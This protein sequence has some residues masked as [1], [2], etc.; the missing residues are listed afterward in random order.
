[1]GACCRREK[2][3]WGPTARVAIPLKTQDA[4]EKTG[5]E[6]AVVFFVR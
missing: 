5:N 6:N 3:A 2:Q 1:M 4:G